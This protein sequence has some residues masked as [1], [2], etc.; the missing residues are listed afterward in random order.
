[1]WERRGEERRVDEKRGKVRKWTDVPLQCHAFHEFVNRL[2]GRVRLLGL[3]AHVG[4]PSSVE[5]EG[6]C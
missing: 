1:V 5:H 4:V 6:V 3:K 2:Q